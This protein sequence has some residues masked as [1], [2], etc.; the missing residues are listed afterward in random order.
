MLIT[1]LKD[2]LQTHHQTEQINLYVGLAIAL[3]PCLMP[4]IGIVANQCFK[5]ISAG[6]NAPSM[7]NIPAKFQDATMKIGILFSITMLAM[8]VLTHFKDQ[9]EPAAFYPDIKVELN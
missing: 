5:N 2:S 9:S 1:S 3:S 6:R 7:Q 4:L 8:V